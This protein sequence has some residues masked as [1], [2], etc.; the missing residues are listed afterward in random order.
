M[1]GIISLEH[2]KK[3]GFARLVAP[4]SE[5]NDEISE[6]GDWYEKSYISVRYAI[7]VDR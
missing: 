4:K 5:S 3:I 2:V 7:W 1:G 6:K